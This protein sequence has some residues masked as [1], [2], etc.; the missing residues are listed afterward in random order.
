MNR[1]VV[2]FAS[3]EGFMVRGL[4]T[5]LKNINVIAEYLPFKLNEI[6]KN[7]A[8]CDK[9]D[10]FIIFTDDS[11]TK[12]YDVLVF[13]KDYSVENDKQIIVIGQKE[14]FEDLERFIPNKYIY[15]YFNRP[16]D[17]EKLLTDVE[18]SVTGESQ[19]GKKKN[20]LIVDDDVSYM[21]MIMDW[22]SDLY[23]ISVA[24]SGM[25]AITWLANNKPDLILLD[26]E[27]PITTG[28]QVLEI[29]LSQTSP[30]P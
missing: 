16:L 4:E 24:N 2:V 22:L 25:Q 20:I 9:A 28:T 7:I 8:R 6:T 5:K 17:M 30:H 18:K 12:Y 1:R 27:M 19:A 11:I 23:R 13:L 21:T 29:L 14:E 26:Y 15:G 3:A 10:M